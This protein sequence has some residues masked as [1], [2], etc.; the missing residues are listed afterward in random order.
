[1][2][3]VDFDTCFYDKLLEDYSDLNYDGVNNYAVIK[4]S[5]V[6]YTTTMFN[7]ANLDKNTKKS[8]QKS[9][10]T[11]LNNKL[12]FLNRKQLYFGS[13]SEI[14]LTNLKYSMLDAVYPNIRTYRAGVILKHKSEILLVKHVASKNWGICK[15]HRE[16]YELTANETALRELYEETRVHNDNFDDRVILIELQYTD[17][18]DLHIYFTLSVDEQPLIRLDKKELCDYDW[19]G[20]NNNIS[21][22]HSTPMKLTLET[23]R[24]R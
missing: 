4:A 21:V 18:T 14:L 17:G 23:L 15:G 5:C 1:M 19:F 24:R 3:E 20:V 22:K 16:D 9:S 8:I 6:K 13:V 11:N 12:Y 7:A 2:T 10:P